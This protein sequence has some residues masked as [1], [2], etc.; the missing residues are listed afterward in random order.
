MLHNVSLEFTDKLWIPCNI[1]I[2]FLNCFLEMVVGTLL[3]LLPDVVQVNC[4]LDFF[5]N[6]VL[7][8]K[9]DRMV[10]FLGHLL[11]HILNSALNILW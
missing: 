4:E 2:T 5:L 6:F 11:N 1:I 3:E 7:D 8:W 9:D 10:V